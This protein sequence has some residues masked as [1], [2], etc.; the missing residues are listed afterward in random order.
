MQISIRFLPALGKL[1][2][3]ILKAEYFFFVDSKIFFS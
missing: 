3:V 1:G 2:R